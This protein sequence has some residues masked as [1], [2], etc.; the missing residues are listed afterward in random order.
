MWWLSSLLTLAVAV[1]PLYPYRF[2]MFGVPIYL[3]EIFIL[4]ALIGWL[5]LLLR[6]RITW[7]RLP[8]WLSLP[9]GLFIVGAALAAAFA[10]THA[11]SLGGLKSW[12]ILPAIF[13]LLGYQ[14][15]I[16]DSTAKQSLSRGLLISAVVVSIWGI[17]DQ[18]S[19]AGRLSSFFNSPNSAAMWLVP[20]FF[21]LL[22]H[23]K[24]RVFQ[25]G[26]SLIGV[27]IILTGSFGGVLALVAGLLVL[28]GLHVH[29]QTGRQTTSL[30]VLWALTALSASAS[31]TSALSH[32]LGNIFGDR[33]GGRLQIWTIARLAL[34]ER[35][36]FGL[37][38]NGF[39]SYYLG[40]VGSV[41]PTP[42]E[43]SVPQPH[44]LY[45]ATWLSSGLLGL[46]SFLTLI[47]ALFFYQVKRQLPFLAA[48]L[49]AMLVHGLIDTTYWKNDL[50]I[51]FFLIVALTA[52]EVQT[53]SDKPER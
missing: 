14:V 11:V 10:D 16:A 27:A 34:G 8:F 49:S 36:W 37:G 48:A 25:I 42:I 19:N 31:L 33:L 20:V 26:L 2:V 30:V 35:R 53:L 18:V 6:R 41:F 28:G 5:F 52:V 1:T 38:P 45:L 51:L 40:K 3:P 21:L 46:V 17:V 23:H 4:L 47:G 43:W 50:S 39:H 9:I 13:G 7:Q 12:V 22:P 24:E 15:L 29:A 44:N 32:W